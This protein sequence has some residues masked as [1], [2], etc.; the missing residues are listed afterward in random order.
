MTVR[1]TPT[2]AAL[3]ALG[4]TEFAMSGNPQNEA[5]FLSAFKKQVGVDE[6]GSAIFSSDPAD[7]GV[8][9]A[10]VVAKLEELEPNAAMNALK[11]KRNKLIASTDWVG[12]EDVP[13]AIKDLWFPYRQ[14][15]RDL[16]ANSPN[17]AFDGQGNLVNVTWPVK[18]E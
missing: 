6:I 14:A 15:L 16:P 17:V 8:T 2:D 3:H 13:Q 11:A 4:I 1:H 18:P 5:E 9:W 7:F 10:Q 12:G